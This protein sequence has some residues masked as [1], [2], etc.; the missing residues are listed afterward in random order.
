MQTELLSYFSDDSSS[1]GLFIA[2]AP[3][4]YGKTYE[5]VQAIYHYVRSGGKKQI[6][7]VT[8]LLKNLPDDELRGA[9]IR[10]GREDCFATEVLRLTAAA[11]AVEKAILSEKIPN[12]F[13]T[14]AYHELLSIC[15]KK[16]EYSKQSSSPV[17]EL[18][19]IL[20]ETI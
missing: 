8:N 2:E 6:L 3:T 14:D 11:D 13:Q 10:D 18:T 9:Y 12:E 17:R 4:G 15:Q 20:E 19:K 1:S 5:T 7:F 16:Q